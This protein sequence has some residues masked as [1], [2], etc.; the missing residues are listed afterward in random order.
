MISCFL[1]SSFIPIDHSI[2]FVRRKIGN[3]KGRIAL[4]NT[5]VYDDLVLGRSVCP[6]SQG[7][8]LQFCIT[9]MAPVC[10]VDLITTLASS[11]IA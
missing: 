11:G 5:E 1:I 6:C 10:S 4:S 2:P 7:L 9:Q 3:E 8:S